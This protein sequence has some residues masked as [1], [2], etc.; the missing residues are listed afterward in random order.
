MK[1][2]EA[3]LVPLCGGDTTSHQADTKAVLAMVDELGVMT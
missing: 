2:G 1:H 3:W